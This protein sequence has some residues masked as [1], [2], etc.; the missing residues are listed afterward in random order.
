LLRWHFICFVGADKAAIAECWQGRFAA[1]ARPAAGRIF[2][3]QKFT[4]VITPSRALPEDF[5]EDFPKI[6]SCARMSSLTRN[7]HEFTGA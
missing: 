2:V 1:L 6:H 3:R 7:S 4:R 5:L